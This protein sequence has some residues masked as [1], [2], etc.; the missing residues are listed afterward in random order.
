MYGSNIDPMSR[1]STSLSMM[2]GGYVLGYHT[3]TII[4]APLIV[5]TLIISVPKGIVVCYPPKRV[6]VPMSVMP[7][8]TISTED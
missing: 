4:I 3:H 1:M 7:W 5:G 2:G 8:K 6:L